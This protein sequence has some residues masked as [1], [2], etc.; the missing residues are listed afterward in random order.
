MI[1]MLGYATFSC[2][3]FLTFELLVANKLISQYLCSAV[4]DHFTFQV[5]CIAVRS[6]VTKFLLDC[7]TTAQV[8]FIFFQFFPFL[9]E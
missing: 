1:S 2:R 5:L 7:Y 8:L 3:I 4:Q 9:S 6:H